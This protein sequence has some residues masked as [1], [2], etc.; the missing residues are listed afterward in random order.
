MD[1][2]FEIYDLERFEKSQ[3][4]MMIGGTRFRR[5]MA[6]GFLHEESGNTANTAVYRPAIL[7]AS[8]RSLVSKRHYRSLVCTVL[9][10]N[11]T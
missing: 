4:L 9:V 1:Q 8:N 11:Q 5:R 2:C 7:Q 6:D 10:D 3:S